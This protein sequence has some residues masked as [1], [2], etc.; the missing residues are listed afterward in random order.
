MKKCIAIA[1][2][3]AAGSL[4]ATE[5]TITTTVTNTVTI[6]EL[7]PVSYIAMFNTNGVAN[8]YVINFKGKANG[9]VVGR[10][11]AVFSPEEA[12]YIFPS[13][14]TVMAGVDEAIN[15]NK[16]MIIQRAK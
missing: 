6:T 8:R 9:V 5:M 15:A 2:L 16:D 1:I 11:T 10:K 13:L 7:E 3:L 14:T 4:C 12:A